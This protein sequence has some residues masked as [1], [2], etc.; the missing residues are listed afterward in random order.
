MSWASAVGQDPIATATA[1]CMAHTPSVQKR[2]WC[3]R[4]SY[5]QNS[6]AHDSCGHC[7]SLGWSPNRFRLS[8]LLSSAHSLF[9]YYYSFFKCYWASPLLSLWPFPKQLRE[10]LL[11]V[12]PIWGL[13]FLYT[14]YD[15]AWR[16]RSFR[17][18]F[19]PLWRS[20]MQEAFVA[21]LLWASLLYSS[22]W[23]S[24]SFLFLLADVSPPFW[25]RGTVPAGNN[26]LLRYLG[27]CK[28]KEKRQLWPSH[29]GY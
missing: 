6:A 28:R 8:D 14:A 1:S 18:V 12:S 25:H 22:L 13:C 17:F 10:T 16:S 3:Y 23:P 7:H 21:N 4:R 26:T 5:Y 27:D 2:A 20:S 29:T 15:K 11:T 19:M 9:V 24:F